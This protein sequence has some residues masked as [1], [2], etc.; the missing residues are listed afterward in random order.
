MLLAQ[1]HCMSQSAAPYLSGS[2][3]AMVPSSRYPLPHL[4]RSVPIPSDSV[5]THSYEMSQPDEWMDCKIDELSAVDD[6]PIAWMLWCWNS[7]P[8]MLSHN[9]VDGMFSDLSSNAV[10][11]ANSTSTGEC[12]SPPNKPKN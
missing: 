7:D 11:L 3:I 10:S 9:I 6:P 4:V 5:R 12:H 1:L 8:T 2:L